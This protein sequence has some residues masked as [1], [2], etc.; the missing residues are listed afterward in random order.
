[1]KS[2]FYPVA[3][4]LGASLLQADPAPASKIPLSGN[5]GW[6]Y[7]AVDAPARRLYVT[8]G[9]RV[10]VVDLTTLQPAGEIGA[11]NGV[12]GVAV[13][14]E[15]GRGFISDGKANAVVV[16]DLASLRVLARWP[17]TGE[18]PDAVLYERATRQVFAFNGESGNATVFDAAT[19]RVNG[20][21]ALGGAPEFPASDGTGQ[22]FVNLEDRAETV[23]LDARTRTVTQHWP[24]APAQTPSALA[25][26]A[27]HHRLFAGC[28]S[29]QLVVLNAESGAVVAVLPI[30]RGVDA[31]SYD[32]G[33]GLVYVS[34]S[35]GTLNVFRQV[36]ADHYN[37]VRTIAT[38]PGARTHAID[39]VTG[40]IFV[41]S[42][43]YLPAT[44]PPPGQTR[45]R[46]EIKPGTFGV[47]V[48]QP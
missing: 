23:R 45:A 7:L 8:H 17:V 39:P 34:N 38:A 15:L 44:P 6:D 24:L 22:V 20:T 26:D 5:G 35:D 33:R 36:D 1:M 31:A 4:L 16:F 40:R 42:A 9:D 3:L 29:Q 14:P 41:S 21:I 12:H 11:L 27:A 48:F 43:D 2:L 25:L 28:R 13:A 19:G 32:A 46:R 10:Q 30:G 37:A 47:L 18:K